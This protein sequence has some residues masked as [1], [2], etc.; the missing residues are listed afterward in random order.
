M[1]AEGSRRPWNQK[2]Y[3][4]SETFIKKDA[5]CP[6]ALIFIAQEKQVK[7]IKKA[8]SPGERRQV[9]MIDE[10]ETIASGLRKP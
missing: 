8:A 5:I 1:K 2:S 7:V 9:A 4:N 3:R 6:F 10:R